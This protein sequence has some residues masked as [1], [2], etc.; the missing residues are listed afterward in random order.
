MIERGGNGA[1]DAAL[2]VDGATAVKL[3]PRDFAGKR[4]MR[5]G[6]FLTGRHHVGVAG[7]HEIGR[8]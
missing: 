1:G 2:H 3:R 8:R 5:P 7:E 6:S 4:R